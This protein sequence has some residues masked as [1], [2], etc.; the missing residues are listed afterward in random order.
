MQEQKFS[1]NEERINLKSN[2]EKNSCIFLCKSN[3][4]ASCTAVAKKVY[5]H[6][7]S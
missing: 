1:C 6:M 4:T 3:M 2:K 5:D 7:S